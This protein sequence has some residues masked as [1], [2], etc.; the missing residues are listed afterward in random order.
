M[1]GPNYRATLEYLSASG[2]CDI[3]MFRYHHEGAAASYRWP[4][5]DRLSNKVST[6]WLQRGEGVSN[7]SNVTRSKAIRVAIVGA[8][9]VANGEA[10]AR[11]QGTG[12]T[13]RVG[14]I[15]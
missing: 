8:A 14:G 12:D 7:A 2:T 4:R 10:P 3:W 11:G 9:A 6:P 1:L 15:S 5:K 13:E